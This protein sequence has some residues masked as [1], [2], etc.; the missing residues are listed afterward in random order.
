MKTARKFPLVKKRFYRPE[1]SICPECQSHLRRAV[2]LSE[3]TVITLQ[4]AI[5]VVHAGY[6]CPNAECAARTRTYRSAQADSLALPGFTFGLDIVLLVGQ[7]RLGQHQTVDEAHRSLLEQL[8]PLELSISRRE[9]LYLFDAYCTLL[10]A[11]TDAKEDS[12]WLAQVKANGG[13]IIS[14]DGIQPDRGNETVYVVRDALTGRVLAAENVT[15]SDTAVLKQILLPLK[16]LPVRILGTL[17]DVQE[18]LLQALEQTWPGVPQQVCQFHALQDASRP[19]YEADRKIKTAMRKYLQPRLKDVRQQIS[20]R[21]QHAS[22]S[23]AEQL[24]VL[25]DY[26]L[27]MQTAL[28]FD[29]LLPFE[30]PAVAAAEALE[31]VESSLQ[32]LEKKGPS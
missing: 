27:G 24:A 25:N 30:Y 31:A 29:G 11:G 1:Q 20:R 17:S 14:M 19:A 18:S 6:R 13:I 23:E 3:R 10:R 22:A 21:S 2:T 9:I 28:H 26:A 5:K 12:Q 16:A 4:G 7:L 32:V 15:A 8:G